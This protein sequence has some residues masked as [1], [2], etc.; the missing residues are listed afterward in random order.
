MKVASF[1]SLCQKHEN[2][3]K[4]ALKNI[5]SKNTSAIRDIGLHLKKVTALHTKERKQLFFV[6]FRTY[7]QNFGIFRYGLAKLAAFPTG[8]PLDNSAFF[9]QEF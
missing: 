2:W 8:N 6:C 9:R 7:E 5:T 3:F 1:I 4:V